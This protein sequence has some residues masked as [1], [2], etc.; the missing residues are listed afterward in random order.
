MMIM[1][2][3]FFFF[4]NIRSMGVT[5]PNHFLNNV[6]KNKNGSGN[7]DIL[8]WKRKAEKYLVEVR[9]ENKYGVYLFYLICFFFVLTLLCFLLFPNI[10]LEWFGLH[11]YSSRWTS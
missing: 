11:N 8:I 3:A 7:G 9:K 5:D 10:F 6:G 2:N 4:F 1:L